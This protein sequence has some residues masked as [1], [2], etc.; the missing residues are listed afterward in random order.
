MSFDE[1]IIE[2][3]PKTKW[4]YMSGNLESYM[5][6]KISSEMLAEAMSPGQGLTLLVVHTP[7]YNHFRFVGFNSELFI[8][9]E[10]F[11]AIVR[12]APELAFR[13]AFLYDYQGTAKEIDTAQYNKNKYG[14]EKTNAD[15]GKVK[16]FKKHRKGFVS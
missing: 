13:K 5:K 8:S 7:D 15:Y 14:S 2:K 6:G 4:P 9:S 12:Y 1:V 16:K 11:E 10:N 3:L